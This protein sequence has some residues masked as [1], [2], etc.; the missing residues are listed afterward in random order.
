MTTLTHSGNGVA[1]RWSQANDTPTGN[2]LLVP[3]LVLL[4][5]VIAIELMSLV[6]VIQ[7]HM[8]E[9]GLRERIRASTPVMVAGVARR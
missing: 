9:A 3:V 7:G 4:A 2:A 6:L 1:D 5:I 8:V